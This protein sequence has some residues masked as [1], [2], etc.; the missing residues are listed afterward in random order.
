MSEIT[1]RVVAAEIVLPLRR[2]VLRP[3]RTLEQASFPEDNAPETFHLAAF[4]GER[5]VGVASLYPKPLP[6][7]VQVLAEAPSSTC[8]WQL[9]GMGVDSSL[10]KRGIGALLL[11]AAASQVLERGGDLLWCNARVSALGFYLAAGFRT[12]GDEFPIPD[13]GPHFV[14]ARSL[15]SAEA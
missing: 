5:V 3:G 9:R 1:I 15:N 2:D 12:F 6:E 8:A 4:E 14:M 10:Q 13:V 7:T 11:R